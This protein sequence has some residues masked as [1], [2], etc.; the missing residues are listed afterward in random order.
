VIIADNLPLENVVSAATLN[1]DLKLHSQF[2]FVKGGKLHGLGGGSATVGCNPIDPG[3]WSVRMNWG[4][5]GAPN[6]YIYHQDRP[7]PCGDH[8]EASNFTFRRGRWYRIDIYVEM[9]SGIE[10]S[11]GRASLYIDG[12]RYVDVRNLNLSGNANVKID[13]FLFHTFYGG[14][15]S[16]HSPSETTYAYF[17]NFTVRPG[18][19]VSGVQGTTC[20]IFEEGIYNVASEVCCAEVCGSCGGPGCNM[21]PGGSS[22][23][24]T[25]TILQSSRVCASQGV[26]S[27]CYF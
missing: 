15:D 19:R 13:T 5:S 9:N 3:G 2:E 10:T 25:G 7:G 22:N 21:L 14:N 6:L 23:C 26:S 1:F 12:V 20:E 16:S 8:Y 4:A 11:D 27:P 17:D 18:H 24:C